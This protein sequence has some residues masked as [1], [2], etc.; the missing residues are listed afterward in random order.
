M[1]ILLL[2]NNEG[3]LSIGEFSFGINRKLT[4]SFMNAIEINRNILDETFNS[5][6]NVDALKEEYRTSLEISHFNNTTIPT[7]IENLLQLPSCQ[8]TDMLYQ[9]FKR[10]IEDDGL[11]LIK[12]TVKLNHALLY[13]LG[14]VPRPATTFQEE[15]LIVKNTDALEI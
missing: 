8:L 11:G 5:R 10:H 3:Q 4:E 2:N 6:P 12:E 15:D 1:N 9:Y 7:T 14:G 13:E